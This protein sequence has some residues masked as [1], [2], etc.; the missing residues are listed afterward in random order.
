MR[1]NYSAVVRSAALPILGTPPSSTISTSRPIRSFSHRA[2][3]RY[4]REFLRGREFAEDLTGKNNS[5]ALSTTVRNWTV[6]HT[7]R[8][9]LCRPR[10]HGNALGE[11]KV[12]PNGIFSARQSHR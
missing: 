3:N 11:I 5:A 9:G 10:D 2:N 8:R 7:G 1:Q 4:A 6:D 12:D